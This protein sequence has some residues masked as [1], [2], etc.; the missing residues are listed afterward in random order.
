MEYCSCT[1]DLQKDEKSATSRIQTKNKLNAP[2]SD[3][4]PRKK[5]RANSEKKRTKSFY[6]VHSSLECN[7]SRVTQIKIFSKSS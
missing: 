2:V 4:N 5:K 7:E 3:Y 1:K 6:G